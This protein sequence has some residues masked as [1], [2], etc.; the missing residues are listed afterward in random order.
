MRRAAAVARHAASR[1]LASGQHLRRGV[2]LYGVPGTGKT[3]TVRYLLGR[4]DAV[5]VVVLS[6]GALGMIAEVTDAHLTAALDQ[7]LDTRSALTQTLLGG[8][9]ARGRVP[10]ASS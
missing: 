7:L 5:T 10:G 4:L 9:P 1:L 6:G 3:H 8:G 2:L